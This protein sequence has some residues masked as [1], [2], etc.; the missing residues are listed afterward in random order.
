MRM[1]SAAKFIVF[2]GID[3]SGKTTVA[4][5][6]CDRLGGTARFTA[7]PYDRKFLGAIEEMLPYSDEDA[8]AAKALSFT[9]DRALHTRAIRGWLGQGMHVVCDRYYMSTVAYQCAELG[10]KEERMRRWIRKINEPFTSL[11]DLVVYL[12]SSPEAA[13]SRIGDRRSRLKEYERAEFLESVRAN[14]S[15]EMSRFKGKKAV[16]RA[17]VGLHSLQ[18]EALAAVLAVTEGAE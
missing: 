18:E 11:P 17:D 6:V 7:E 13:L 8:V 14:Y 4:K 5:H 10:P 1:H 15:L 9:A 12:D 16:I 2:E 3:G